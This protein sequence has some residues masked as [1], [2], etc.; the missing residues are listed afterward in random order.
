MVTEGSRMSDKEEGEIVPSNSPKSGVVDSLVDTKYFESNAG[1][2]TIATDHYITGFKLATT[3]VSC[4]ISLF[5]IALDQTIV[6]TILSDVGN[7]FKSFEKIGW[8]TSGYLLPTATLTPSYG[9]MAIAFGRKLTMLGGIIV[10]EV[11]SLIAALSNSMSMLIGGRVIQGF[12]G[13]CIQSMVFLIL[14]ESVPISKRP[15]SFVL[16]GV[17]FSVASVLGP[18]VGGALA[19]HV[20][21]RWCFYINLPI[22]GVAFVLLVWGF[23]P[24]KPTGNLRQKLARIDYIGT[25][26]LV[27]G[28]VLV[29]LGLTFGGIDFPWRSAAV[30]CCFVL[31]GVILLIFIYY[32][33]MVSKKPII[34]KEVITIPQ[35]FAA[36]AS[37]LFNFGF[38]MVAINYLAVYFQVIFNASAWKSGVDL[39]PLVIS[40]TVS[41]ILNGAFMR[42]T[43]YVKITMMFSAVCAP[44]GAGL[45][46]LLDVDS[47]AKDRIGLLIV[48]GVSIG[49]QFQSSMIAAQL[50]TPNNIEGSLIQVTIFLNFLKT[51]GGTIAISI[52][53]LIFQ[54]SGTSYIAHAILNLSPNSLEY[55]ELIHVEPRTIIESPSLIRSFSPSTQAIILGQI[56]RAIKNTFYLGLALTSASFITSIFTTNKRLPKDENIRQKDSE[57]IGDEITKLAPANNS[58]G[59]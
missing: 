9:K 36:C 48:A 35:I 33:F 59:N 8:L 5:I 31:G 6:L 40:V 49:L 7:Q 54:T 23:Q 4:V 11:G 13:G 20:S 39:L 3:L 27:A 50:R 25:F 41:S 43:R 37:A 55:Q 24:P 29:L 45:F 16:I 28:L 2:G 51:L 42:F 26:L 56:M 46:L 1:D 34:I 14:T 10:F 52:G 44:L 47:P 57:A 22:G 21:W 15:L 30:I 18:F 17:T 32:N 38:F 12:G 19:T 58:S 53:Q